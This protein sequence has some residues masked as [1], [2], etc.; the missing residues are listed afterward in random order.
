ML[1]FAEVLNSM[2]GSIIAVVEAVR[3]VDSGAA[4]IYNIVTVKFKIYVLES[5]VI[6]IDSAV[7]VKIAGDFP[8]FKIG[9]YE[10]REVVA[11]HSLVEVV[12]HGGNRIIFF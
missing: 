5:Y 2:E 12:R 11:Y 4:K 9:G 7:I 8:I 10:K 3:S 1:Y 6:G